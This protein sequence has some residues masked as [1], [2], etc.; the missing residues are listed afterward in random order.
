MYKKYEVSPKILDAESRLREAESELENAKNEAEEAQKNVWR[1]EEEV[2]KIGAEI[3]D[4]KEAVMPYEDFVNDLTRL[5]DELTR[6]WNSELKDKPVFLIRGKEKEGYPRA[7]RYQYYPAFAGS[8]TEVATYREVW[9]W[10][11]RNNTS[12]LNEEDPNYSL[13]KK[14]LEEHNVIIN[15]KARVS[16]VGYEI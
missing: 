8:G 12:F 13:F 5:T 11:W 1:R 14:T 15:T 2:S 10:S 7:N 16:T 3:R 4:K 9:I 6:K